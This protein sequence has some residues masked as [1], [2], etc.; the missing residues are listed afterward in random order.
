MLY[1]VLCLEQIPNNTRTRNIKERRNRKT[2]R[3]AKS[4]PRPEYGG[5]GLGKRNIP[6]SR[7][8]VRWRSASSC[9]MHHSSSSW[10]TPWG[11]LDI[12]WG[13]Q[14]VEKHKSLT[15]KIDSKTEFSEAF[16]PLPGDQTWL[17]TGGVL[18]NSSFIP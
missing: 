3:S 12:V 18:C 13:R 1:V 7:C 14:N 10:N 17:Y 8:G 15:S 4:H 6:S 5:C 2:P 11:A 16:S 9:E